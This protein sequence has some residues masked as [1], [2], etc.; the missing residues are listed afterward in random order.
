M[1]PMSNSNRLQRGILRC[2]I[3]TYCSYYSDDHYNI[4]NSL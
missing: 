3:H 1:L 2:W 4:I